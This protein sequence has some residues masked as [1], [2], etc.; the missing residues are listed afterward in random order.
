M[1]AATTSAGWRFIPIVPTG[2]LYHIAYPVANT[3][4]NGL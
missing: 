1:T 2:D 4:P 3:I